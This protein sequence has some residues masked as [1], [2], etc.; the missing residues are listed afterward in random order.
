MTQCKISQEVQKLLLCTLFVCETLLHDH[1]KDFTCDA[2]KCET[3]YTKSGKNLHKLFLFNLNK[4]RKSGHTIRLSR[5]RILSWMSIRD[6]ENLR[7][8]CHPSS[9][10]STRNN[11]KLINQKFFNFLRI[12]RGSDIDKT[13][14]FHHFGAVYTPAA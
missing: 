8:L 12:L 7:L 2:N 4:R 11:K 6:V 14:I 3:S 10:K 13:T 5:R 1:F 9:P